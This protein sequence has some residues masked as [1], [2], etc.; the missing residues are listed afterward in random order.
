M[1]ENIKLV[2]YPT[3]DMKASKALFQAFLGV[4]PYAD[5]EYYV[6]YKAGNLE[7]GLVPGG[8]EEII[9][10]I[11]T[12]DIKASLKALVDAGATVHQEPK[13]VAEGLLVAQ[14]KDASGNVLGLRQQSTK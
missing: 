2:V 8:Q 1:A 3:K 4:E 10:Y 9:A 7:V 11:D 14:V 5:S 12:D 13:D 6:G